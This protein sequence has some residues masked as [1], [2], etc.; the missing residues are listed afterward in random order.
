MCGTTKWPPPRNQLKLMTSKSNNFIYFWLWSGIGPAV[1]QHPIGVF[2]VV[3]ST[4][5]PYVNFYVFVDNACT[6]KKSSL[7]IGSFLPKFDLL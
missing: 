6:K 4:M 7:L 3:F 5:Q 2:E 1:Y